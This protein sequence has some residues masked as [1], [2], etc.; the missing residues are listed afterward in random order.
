[1]AKP[2]VAHHLDLK[3]A[4]MIHLSDTQT[5][6]NSTS[7]MYEGHQRRCSNRQYLSQNIAVGSIEHLG[8][9]L[10]I[11][12]IRRI[13]CS[14]SV[15]NSQQHIVRPVLTCGDRGRHGSVSDEDGG[16]A[17]NVQRE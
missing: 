4:L 12:Y 9:K 1:M 8:R 13:L 5:S 3:I 7:R 14:G 17:D 16:G 2:P 6:V 10:I 15:S 11:T